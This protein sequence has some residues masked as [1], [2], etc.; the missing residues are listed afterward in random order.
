MAKPEPS[1]EQI[2]GDLF[3]NVE[4]LKILAAHEEAN[5]ENEERDST[6][7]RKLD[8]AERAY[9][10]VTKNSNIEGQ[11]VY[12]A[13]RYQDRGVER[14]NWKLA[15]DEQSTWFK[16][17][18]FNI[19]SELSKLDAFNQAAGSR[20]FYLKPGLH[21]ISTSDGF[22]WS[23]YLEAMKSYINST[24]E[25]IA[26]TGPTENPISLKYRQVETD[27][28]RS[29]IE[30]FVATA[31]RY[32]DISRAIDALAVGEMLQEPETARLIAER[33]KNLASSVN[34]KDRQ[35]AEG[36]VKKLQDALKPKPPEAPVEQGENKWKQ[37]K[38]GLSQ[39]LFWQATSR[40]RT[41]DLLF[42]PNR[43]ALC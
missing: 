33:I 21:T 34:V 42:L 20:D 16:D 23:G 4:E 29:H 41:E 2:Y 17:S 14:G 6:F 9:E 8:E 40:I 26:K 25:N 28:P 10:G 43:H 39:L 11:F 19:Q 18:G 7:K 3:T 37:Q 13:L 36:L 38:P 22:T 27:G 32:N 35:E 31:F 12:S 5:K 24:K 15:L 1:A 30:G